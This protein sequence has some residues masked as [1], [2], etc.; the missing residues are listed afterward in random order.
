MRASQRDLVAAP[1]PNPLPEGE[2]IPVLEVVD[3][4]THFPTSAGTV[5]AVD[6]VSFRVMPGETV[7]IVGESG[8]GKSMTALSVMRLLEPPGYVAKGKSVSAGGTCC[9][10][11]PAAASRH[12][13]R[14]GGDGVP[15]PDDLAQP[16]AAHRRQMEEAMEVHGQPHREAR[17]RA[18]SLLGPHGHPQPG[19]RRPLL[20]APVQRRHAPARGDRHGHEQRA[21]APA[22]RRADHGA[23][24]HHPGADPRADARVEPRF[25][26]R[27]RADQPRSRRHRRRLL[28]GAG[29]VCGRGGRGGQRRSRAR[30]AAPPLHLGPDER[31]AAAGRRGRRAADYDRGHAAG[32]AQRRRRAA[33]S[34]P[35]CPFRV[36]QCAEHPAL[37]PMGEGRTSRCWVAA[38]RRAFSE[39]RPPSRRRS[40]ASPVPAEGKPAAAGARPGQAFRPP[41][42]HVRPPPGGARRRRHRPRHPARRGPRRRRRERLRQEHARPHLDAA[43]APRRGRDP[44]RRRADRARGRMP[45]SAR[46][47]GACR[48]CSRTLMP[49][50]TRA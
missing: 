19:A 34:R 31:G 13:R 30:R 12:A 15:G 47:G 36:E 41:R 27:H 8:S 10:M 6:G 46:C 50:S 17:R 2:G 7:G 18:V 45:R 39:G 48:W 29:D 16:G 20:S 25:R 37:F 4:A 1:S 32:P 3:L 22:R 49:A 21:R 44:V 26:H 9:A 40:P 24:R 23:R 35:R 38:G 42:R 14:R 33:A 43:L 28:A 11:R 5:R